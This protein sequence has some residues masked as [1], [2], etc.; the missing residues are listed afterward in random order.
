VQPLTWNSLKTILIERLEGGGG[1]EQRALIFN[2]TAK[3][4]EEKI[5]N[6]EKYYLPANYA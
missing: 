1:S 6:F 4:P 2:K 5:I 3:Q